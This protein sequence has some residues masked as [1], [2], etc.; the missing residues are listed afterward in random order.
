[1]ANSAEI[2]KEYMISSLLLK[3]DAIYVTPQA[4]AAKTSD[5]LY[6]LSLLS[7]QIKLFPAVNPDRIIFQIPPV[8]LN[9]PF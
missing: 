7:G 1:M 8:D 6:R 9:G 3:P 5:H 4:W 2:T